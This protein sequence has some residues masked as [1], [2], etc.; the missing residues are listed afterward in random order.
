M[1]EIRNAVLRRLEEGEALR[2]ICRDP[3]MPD[4]V[5]VWR[6]IDEDEAFRS[7]YAQARAKGYDERAERMEENVLAE[8]DVARARL[9]FDQQRWYLGKMAP[10]KYGDK[11][12]IAGD[13][14]APV[15]VSLQ[16]TFK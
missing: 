12:T 13:A 4:K 2:A 8:P 16:V 9:L 1:T 6:W 3:D 10:K 14:D 15:A 5:T 11:T 7:Q